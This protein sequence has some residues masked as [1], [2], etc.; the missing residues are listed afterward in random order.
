MFYIG[1]SDR[2]DITSAEL[3]EF[4]GLSVEEA[5]SNGGSN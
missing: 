4:I 1:T 3:E 5:G 2:L